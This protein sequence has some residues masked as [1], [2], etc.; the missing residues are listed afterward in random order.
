MMQKKSFENLDNIIC[1][2]METLVLTGFV[3]KDENQNKTINVQTFKVEY[4]RKSL[5]RGVI[6]CQRRLIIYMCSY[7]YVDIL[8]G[9]GKYGSLVGNR[10]TYNLR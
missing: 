8:L 7:N 5:V 4:H 10:Q 9:T 1:P 3:F 6:R 2:L